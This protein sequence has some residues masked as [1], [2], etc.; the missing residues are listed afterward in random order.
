MLH[1]SVLQLSVAMR[2]LSPA[3]TLRKPSINTGRCDF[4]DD[5]A[6]AKPKY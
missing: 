3:V 1:V 5:Y 2:E 4:K 6:D